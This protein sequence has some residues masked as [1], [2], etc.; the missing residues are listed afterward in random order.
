M[1]RF[2]RRQFLQ[3]STLFA[4]AAAALGPSAFVAQ[5]AKPAKKVG[6]NERIR[7]ACIGFNG[8][9]RS[10]LGQFSTLPDTVITTLCDVDSRLADDGIKSVA[11]KQKVEPVFVQ[12]LRRIMDDKNIDVVSIATPNHWHALAAIWAIQAGKDVYVEKPVSHNVW[13][14]RRIVD[15]AR[16]KGRIVQTGTQSRSNTGMREALDYI[17]SGKIGDVKVAYGLCYKGRGSIGPRKE[18]QIPKEVDYDLWCGP[19]QVQPSFR[20]GGKG[21]IHYDWH[22]FWEFGN[23][24]L[25]NQGIHEMDKARWGLKKHALPSAV[26]SFGG[27]F[28]YEDAGETANTQVCWFDYGDAQLIFEVRGLPTKD[29]RGSKVGNIW[30]GT[31]GYVV[32][33]SYDAAVAFS[34]DG[35]ELQK[36]KGGANHYANFIKAVKSR[37]HTDLNADIAEGHLSSALCH[38]GNISYR[39]GTVDTTAAKKLA[40][41]EGKE[42]LERMLAHL[43]D[44]KVN[45]DDL[46]LRV[47]RKLKLDPTT[48]RFLGDEEANK[49]LSREYRK[50]FEVPKG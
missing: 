33:G 16:Q 24:D 22:W 11:A 13:E 37:K 5:E 1:S 29:Y 8:Q 39:L 14:G 21:P 32:S 6:A 35:Q 49:M 50:G 9:G 7:V 44:N 48:E 47:G 15:F 43:K 30:Q 27:R 17:H 31:N 18:V 19:A 26:Y 36:F 42:P 20:N 3:D 40:V 34:P 41:A 25:G 45:V 28:G 2:S 23:G 46:P 4:A 10:H 38:L 12:D